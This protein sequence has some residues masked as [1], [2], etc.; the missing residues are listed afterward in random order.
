MK[1]AR[2]MAK[3]LKDSLDA[4]KVLMEVFMT[5]F[6]KKDFDKLYKSLF[7]SKRKYKVRTREGA[8]VDMKIGNMIIPII[9]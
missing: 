7:K 4:E 9:D 1:K 5:K 8:C 2:E 6:E 3:K